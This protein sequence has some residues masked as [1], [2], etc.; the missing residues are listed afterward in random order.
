MSS[1]KKAARSGSG[2][3]KSDPSNESLLG[4]TL[5]LTRALGQHGYHLG[6]KIGEGSFSS[7]RLAKC[8]SK[9]QN[10]QTLACKVID[11]R[12]GSEE[13]VRK[14]FPRELSVLMK[15]RHPY[16]IKIHSIFKRER[17]VFIFMTY[18]ERGDLL[19]FINENGP[20][21]ENQTKRWFAQLV[22]ALQYLHAID[23]AHRDLKCENILLSKAGSVLLADFGFAR[24]CGEENGAF[25][26]T[27]CG[28]SAYA[29]P[30]VILGKPY[31]PMVADVWSL[32]IVLF[33][34]L[35][36]AMPFEDGN[37]KKLVD[38][39]RNRNY[40]FVEAV[41]KDLSLPAKRTVFELLNPNPNERIRLNQLF[42]LKWIDR[43]STKEP[44][45][46][47]GELCLRK[48][49]TTATGSTKT[50]GCRC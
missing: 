30:E 17:M 2:S 12:K 36:A 3:S 35:N 26:E 40:G 6:A 33:V 22:Y 41:G 38:D 43:N 11:V 1:S 44:K 34:M 20:I 50:T 49:T 13:F 48:T 16:I 18:A 28:S 23:I 24:V 8:V 10:V 39:H 32:G 29:A 19:R 45:R 37:V 27:Y 46:S 4:S 21:K 15:V 31:N 42:G 7:V 25:S 14:F 5:S 47:I 9:N